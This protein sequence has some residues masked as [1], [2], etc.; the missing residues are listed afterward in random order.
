MLD[1]KGVRMAGVLGF[2]LAGF[3][4]AGSPGPATLSLA[5]AGAAFGAPRGLRYLS[6]LVVGMV[7]VMVIIAG[8]LAGAMLALPGAM[9]TVTT[10]AA[11]YFAYLAWRI[12]TAPPLSER[13][14][15]ERPP[16]FA[17]GLLL[18]LVNPK[19]YVAMAALFSG[20]ALARERILLD[21]VAKTAALTAII[22]VVNIAWLF[23]GAA[24][25]RCFQEKRSNRIINA[26]FALLLVVSAVAALWL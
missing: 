25:T 24:L 15:L 22:A 2:A 16:S 13:T 23:A 1:G 7:I 18:S 9:P 5:A 21:A 14:G 26:S 8:G 17:G 12:A 4:L 11:G 3:A 10:L 20:F 19:G 6:G